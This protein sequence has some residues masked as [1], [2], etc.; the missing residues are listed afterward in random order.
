MRVW[1][2]PFFLQ[3]TPNS[4]T[5]WLEAGFSCGAISVGTVTPFPFTGCPVGLIYGPG[6][7]PGNMLRGRVRRYDLSN[8][9]LVS[10]RLGF[11]S[12]AVFD[13]QG[14]PLPDNNYPESSFFPSVT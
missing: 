4:G 2:A 6:Q 14:N 9:N 11:P 10:T 12:G 1:L 8:D 7:F 3:V 13:S 5:Y